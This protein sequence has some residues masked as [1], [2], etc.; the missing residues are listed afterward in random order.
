MASWGVACFS[1]YVL[2]YYVKYFS[3]SILVNG[4]LL[5]CADITAA[6]IGKTLQ[7]CYSTK[8]MLMT[9]FTIAGLAGMLH[10]VVSVESVLY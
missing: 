3:G 1:F 9:G 4:L 10:Y 8:T 5:G 7:K 6:I 2:S